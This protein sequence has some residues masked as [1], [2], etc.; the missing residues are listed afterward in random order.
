MR[1]LRSEPSNFASIETIA[2]HIGGVPAPA[3]G[4][5]RRPAPG[6]AA[7]PDW[8][9]LAQALI[10]IGGR[11][12]SRRRCRGPCLHSPVL[13]RREQRVWHRIT[14]VSWRRRWRRKR[15]RRQPLLSS[16]INT[17]IYILCNM[18]YLMTLPF[19][20]WGGGG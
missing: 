1:L 7:A 20:G 4:A 18:I 3:Q 12:R 9:G 8:G 5:H 6:P 19:K 2:L 16:N 15:W 13:A 14:H 11:A 10:M 17:T